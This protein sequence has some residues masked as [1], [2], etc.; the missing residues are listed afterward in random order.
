[1][2]TI[3]FA[4]KTCPDG[5]TARGQS[6]RNGSGEMAVSIIFRGQ[7][8]ISRIVEQALKNDADFRVPGGPDFSCRTGPDD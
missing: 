8:S 6:V 2:N 4:P 7:R 5:P 1:M 3:S